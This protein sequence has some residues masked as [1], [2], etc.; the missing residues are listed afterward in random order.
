MPAPIQTVIA[1]LDHWQTAG[2]LDRSF[3]DY[4]TPGTVWENVG[5][6]TT[7]GADEAVALNAQLGQSLGI[8]TIRVE[9]RAIAVSDATE[10]GVAKVLTERLDH[11]LDSTGKVLFSAA[12]MGIFEVKDGKII[13]WRDYFDTAGHLPKHHEESAG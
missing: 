8:A 7:T 10:G 13:A 6:A 4:F 3:R 1:F 11:M 5:V 9:M 12:C 2:G